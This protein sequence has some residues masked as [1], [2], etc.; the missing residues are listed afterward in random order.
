MRPIGLPEGV[1]RRN[2]PLVRALCDMDHIDQLML[3]GVLI[4]SADTA[5]VTFRYRAD[6]RHV[7][8]SLIRTHEVEHAV[9]VSKP[10]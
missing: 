1:V 7:T 9:G 10:H 4:H 6:L 5:D 3:L 8:V 2:Q